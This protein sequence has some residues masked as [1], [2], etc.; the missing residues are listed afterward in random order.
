VTLI[1]EM[2]FASTLASGPRLA[3]VLERGCVD[4]GNA[5]G[6]VPDLVL[7]FAAPHY[8]SDLDRLPERV[9]ATL[10]GATV[11][12]CTAH[13]VIG[14]RLEVEDRPAVAMVGARLPG[15]EIAPFALDESAVEEELDVPVDPASDPTFLLLPDPFTSEPESLV[16]AFDR[17][18]PGAVVLGG[19][20]SGARRPGD[21]RLFLGDRSHRAGAVG[22]ALSGNLTVET[23]VAQGCRPIGQPMFATRVKGGVLYELDG[24]PALEV[25]QELCE[26]LC[27][28]DRELLRSALFLGI[29]MRE[30]R[31]VYRPG[32]FLIRN[33]IGADPRCG[34]L[35][36]AASLDTC[37]V[38]QFHVRDA[39]AS[40]ADLVDLLRSREAPPPT[41]ALLFSCTG[42]GAFLYG[43]EGH[44]SRLF[45][46][47]VGDLPLGG[48][49]C[50]G[51]IGPVM[52]RTFV[53]GYTSS[54]GLF[55]PRAS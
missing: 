20:A 29:A 26:G 39:A 51:E 14:G 11:L 8:G 54:F 10:P 3:D 13:G 35:A 12:G 27:P 52:G 46:E 33:L 50:N 48:F 18:Y 41:G 16:E 34:A 5:L 42:R 55:R 1:S 53:H 31:E 15:V 40:T 17:R 38:V 2:R 24:R 49:F 30:A 6:A 25:L 23:V 45:R 32:D 9:A 37:A 47:H 28:K 22:V 4:L 7:C 43:E 44:D 21:H 19:L 36:A